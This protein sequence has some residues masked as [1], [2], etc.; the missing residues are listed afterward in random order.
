MRVIDKNR[1]RRKAQRGFSLLELIV[2]VSILTAVIAVVTDGI[3]HIEK[4]SASDVNKVGLAQESRQF[5]DQILRDLR[6]SGYPSLAMFD[7]TTLTSSTDCTLDNNVACGLISFSSSAIQFEG[8]ID[9]SGVSEVYIQVSGARGRKLSLHRAARDSFEIGG[10]HPGLLHGARQRNESEHLHGVQVRRLG[11]GF[12]HRNC[13]PDQEYWRHVV[14][15]KPDARCEPEIDHL[16]HDDNGIG[17]EN[18]Q[19]ARSA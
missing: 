4:K 19:L 12:R 7:P 2:A 16:P 10:R 6:Q 17:S 1:R 8:D 5:M 13:R 14:C 15:P 9:G 18:Q 11:V 3:M